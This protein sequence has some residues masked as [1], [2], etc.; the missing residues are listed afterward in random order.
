[1]PGTYKLYTTTQTCPSD[2]S[3]ITMDIPDVS[4]SG[5]GEVTGVSIQP[6]NPGNVDMIGNEESDSEVWIPMTGN[7]DMNDTIADD[8][9]PQFKS[10]SG[11]DENVNFIFFIRRY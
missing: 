3:S 10:T 1:M 8:A 5:L 11:Q 7:L 6:V 4:S 9:K 2:G